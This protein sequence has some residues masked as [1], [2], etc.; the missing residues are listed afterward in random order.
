M[1]LC[2]T[3][4]LGVLNGAVTLPVT[5]DAWPKLQAVV[6]GAGHKQSAGRVP[7]QTT[8]AALETNHDSYYNNGQRNLCWGGGDLNMF[9]FR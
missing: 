7:A 4:G 5:L 1:P 8:D 3:D 2:H 9:L 6:S